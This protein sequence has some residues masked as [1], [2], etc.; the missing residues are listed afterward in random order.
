MKNGVFWVVTPCGSRRNN[1]EDTI[2][3]YL[4]GLRRIVLYKF[5]DDSGEPNASIFRL[6][7]YLVGLQFDFEDGENFRSNLC[8]NF[9]KTIR[10]H[11]P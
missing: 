5:P 4:L 1:P 3:R 7:P 10:F 9:H 2:L 11:I 6:Y 8:V